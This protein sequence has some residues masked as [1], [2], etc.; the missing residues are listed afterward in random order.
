ME[1]SSYLTEAK[2]KKNNIDNSFILIILINSK[3][4]KQFYKELTRTKYPVL[5]YLKACRVRLKP[6][7]SNNQKQ[8]SQ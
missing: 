1:A 6:Q 5:K 7:Y 8:M 4:I 2:K 3:G